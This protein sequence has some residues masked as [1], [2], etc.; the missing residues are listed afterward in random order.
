MQV[1][2]D[3]IPAMKSPL[4]TCRLLRVLI[5]EALDSGLSAGDGEGDDNNDGHPRLLASRF[6]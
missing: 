6:F 4:K 2:N 5:G 3:L 1:W